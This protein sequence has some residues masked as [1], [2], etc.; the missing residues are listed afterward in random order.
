MSFSTCSRPGRCT[1]WNGN[2]LLVRKSTRA[3]RSAPT[4][5]SL[6]REMV[7]S[8]G[9]PR[10]DGSPVRPERVPGHDRVPGA[11]AE[12]RGPTPCAG[13][14][15]LSGWC[16]GV[17]RCSGDDETLGGAGAVEA[18]SGVR[19][20]HDV[21]PRGHVVRLDV[22][23]VEVEG[24]LPHVEHDDR[25]EAER[26]VRLLVVELDDDEL[27]AH[28]VP[29]EDRPARA[30]DAQ[31]VGR[32]VLLEGLEG[33]EELVDRRSQLADGLAALGGEDLPEDRVVHVAAEV[34]REVLL[35]QVH[36]G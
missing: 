8:R 11:R 34:E 22:D 24:V 4:G 7:T 27:L 35:V 28:R 23:V 33:A 5:S 19:P 36:R 25:H 29:R 2:S 15:A 20:V 13:G 21:P 16:G 26:D 12:A 10:S 17:Q 32:E 6:E 30:L 9:Y 18:S 3:A 1:T 14:S 31:R